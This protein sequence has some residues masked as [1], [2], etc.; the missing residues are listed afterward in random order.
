M[1]KKA[2]LI[3]MAGMLMVF[4]NVSTMASQENVEDTKNESEYA[5]IDEFRDFKWGISKDEIISS[6]ITDDMVEGEDYG[7]IGDG[8]TL[9]LINGDVAGYD[10][11][12]YYEF[13]DDWKLT[14]GQ[15]VL[16]EDHTNENDYYDDYIDITSKYDN[17]YGESDH[18]IVKWKDDTYKGKNDKIG[19]AIAI[20]D[21]YIATEWI[22]DNGSRI[23]AVIAGDNFE[24]NTSITYRS[25]DYE[26]RE[27]TGGV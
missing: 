1:K 12:I 3:L 13:N 4:G 8:K 14:Q 2:L 16:K 9:V 26:E 25:P 10:S 7:F 19:M 17:K 20:G 22:D 21:L 6:V 27:N 15:Y 18:Q 24:I 23:I 5:P 11:Y